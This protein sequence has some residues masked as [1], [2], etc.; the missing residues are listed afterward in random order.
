MGKSLKVYLD[1]DGVLV[2]FFK[3]VCDEFGQPYNYFNLIEYSF[4][5]SWG[6]TRDQVNS[7]CDITFWSDLE[8]MHDGIEILEAVL[9]RFPLDVH[10]LTTPM[11]NFGSWT[12]KARWVNEHIPVFNKRLIITQ[13]P[14]SLFAGPGTLLVDDK[15]ENITEFVKAGG[16]GILVPRP[17]N[18][19]HYRANET[20]EVVKKSSEVLCE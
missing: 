5:E 4:W 12:G 11:P 18:E 15:D 13:E 10:L 6:I 14:K 20:L 8:W 1:L 16:M 19:L 7:R 9:K 2:N 17:W 3:G